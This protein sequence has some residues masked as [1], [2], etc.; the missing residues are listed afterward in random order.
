MP[1]ELLSFANI[2]PTGSLAVGDLAS[3]LVPVGSFLPAVPLKKLCVLTTVRAAVE[4]PRC[5]A[6]VCMLSPP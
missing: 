2:S 5:Q 1:K 3:E 6:R 4:H